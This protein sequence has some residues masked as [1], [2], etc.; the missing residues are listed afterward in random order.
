MKWFPFEHM[1]LS[2]PL[3][4]EEVNE[5]VIDGIKETF[6]KENKRSLLQRFLEPIPEPP[7]NGLVKGNWFKISRSYE[8]GNTYGPV[9]IGKITAADNGGSLIKIHLR[10]PTLF[11]FLTCIILMPATLFF[12]ISILINQLS[13]KIPLA[14]HIPVFIFAFGYGLVLLGYNVG[15]RSMLDFLYALLRTE[16][17]R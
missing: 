4:P 1:T 12:S 9:V 5:R 8:L 16:R 3:S 15:R 17:M 7:F 10:L 14:L 13:G 2:S 6:H 11:L